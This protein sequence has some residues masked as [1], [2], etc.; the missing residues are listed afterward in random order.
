MET[1]FSPQAKAFIEEWRPLK[2]ALGHKPFDPDAP[3]TLRFQEQTRQRL[4]AFKEKYP[5]LEEER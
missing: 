1:C 3:E 2:Q 4:K 5:A